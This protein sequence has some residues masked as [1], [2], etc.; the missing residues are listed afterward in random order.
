MTESNQSQCSNH[1]EKSAV[2]KCA[3]CG[4]AICGDC[5]IKIG[6]FV[7]CPLCLDKRESLETLKEKNLK[8]LT[9]FFFYFQMIVAI[10]ILFGFGIFCFFYLP[11]D[12]IYAAFYFWILALIYFFL[13]Y[14]KIKK[15]FFSKH[16]KRHK[17]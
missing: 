11:Q 6:I 16:T 10:L 3:K 1:P 4:K 12:N 9:N 7:F 14:P 17:Y 15:N 2:K 13:D 8:Y 5:T